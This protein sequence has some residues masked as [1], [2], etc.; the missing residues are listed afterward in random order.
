MFLLR[1]GTL[2]NDRDIVEPGQVWYSFSNKPP[3]SIRQVG[4]TWIS[5]QDN[6]GIW[7]LITIDELRKEY[8]YVGDE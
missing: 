8:H 3:I 1:C 2:Q 5:Y 4:D 7:K 6:K